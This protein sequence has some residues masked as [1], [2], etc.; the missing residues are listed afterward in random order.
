[1]ADFAAV[2]ILGE[3]AMTVARKFFGGLLKDVNQREDVLAKDM[4][5]HLMDSVN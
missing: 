5:C 2:F 4:D 3:E 1:V